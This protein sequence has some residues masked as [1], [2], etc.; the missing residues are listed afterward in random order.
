M[1]ATLDSGITDAETPIPKDKKANRTQSQIDELIS[2][3]NDCTLKPMKALTPGASSRRN[4]VSSDAKT[5]PSTAE[6]QLS[7]STPTDI[8]FER[9][10][11]SN[12]YLPE[13]DKVDIREEHPL[14]N[15]GQKS[16]PENQCFP[17]YSQSSYNRIRFFEDQTKTVDYTA[18]LPKPKHGFM[19]VTDRRYAM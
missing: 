3:V 16:K 2:A 6:K 1:N 14:F 15:H 4:T 10:H 12:K 11:R 9:W 17:E 19:A 13:I 18:N 7:S 5:L 8:M